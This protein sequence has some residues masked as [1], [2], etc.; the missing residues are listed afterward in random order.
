MWGASGVAK[1]VGGLFP[2]DADGNAWGHPEL[3]LPK[4]LSEMGY[5]L[6]HPD[7]YQPM[8][9]DFSAQINAYK[10][11]GCEI[12]TGVMIPPDFGTFWAQAAQQG[13]NPKVVTIGKALLFPSFVNSLGD[14]G[15]GLT[16]EIWWTHQTI[17]FQV[18]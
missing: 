8:S 5:K 12:V 1:N 15:N 9:D 14:R 10:D 11:A 3:G 6:I 4:P 7:H 13:F 17:L 18:A 16:S 2:N